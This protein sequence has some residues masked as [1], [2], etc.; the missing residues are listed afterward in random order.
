MK[1]LPISG[2]TLYLFLILSLTPISAETILLF[3]DFNNE[4]SGLYN[5]NYC[6]KDNC[7]LENW[8]ALFGSVD[9]CGNGTYDFYPG[10]GLYLDLDGSTGQA[11]V[12][13]SKNEFDLTNG[14][15]E[16]SFDIGGSTRGDTNSLTVTLGD[17]FIQ[18]FTLTQN[19]PMKNYAFEIDIR[20]QTNVNNAYL[21]F[22]HSNDGDLYGILLDNVKLIQIYNSEN[23]EIIDT[24][25]DG[26]IDELDKC[27]N[28]PKN[29]FVNKDGCAFNGI[30]I[31]QTQADQIV[32]CIN[33][34]ITILDEIGLKDA[35]K[36]LEITAG[37]KR[38]VD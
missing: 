31:D 20:N 18:R 3:D 28:T 25:H 37:M 29:S 12:L 15:Y 16:L 24:D 7:K 34:I 35:I 14:L 8:I 23:C 9:L 5:E 17:V 13:K 4:N 21:T 6:T 22:E 38:K 32:G 2:T 1:K 10:N 11:V 26:V 30:V 19:D 27:A 36:A 33:N